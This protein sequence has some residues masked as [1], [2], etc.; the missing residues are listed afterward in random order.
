MA[1]LV[2]TFLVSFA[3]VLGAYWLF[4]LRHEIRHKASVTRRLKTY[5]AQ[6]SGAGVVLTPER[7]SSIPWLDAM[8]AGRKGLVE[9]VR[10]LVLEAG[11]TI[12]VG[13][14]LLASFCG[15]AA[16]FFVGAQLLETL[17]AALLFGILGA[18]V[19]YAYVRFKR[20]VRLR[21]FEEQFP[22]AMDL[23]SRALRAGHAF[24]TGIGMVA[25]E[26]PAPVGSEFRRLY[27]QQNFGMSLP[28]AMRE[29]ASRVPVL[30]AK[31]FVTAV[32]TQREA[33][34]NLSE[35]LDNLASVM[36]D[37]FKLRRQIRVVSAH[38]RISAF[39][40][41]ALPPVLA[42]LMFMIS[43]HL[44][45]VLTTDPVGVRLV[46]IALVLQVVGTVMIAR[47]VKIEY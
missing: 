13:T 4:V 10:V 36:R 45:S 22:E 35:V 24:T 9:R 25:D 30:D 17:L 32:L 46:L 19:P 26:I 3:T 27:D 14:F 44:M 20:S 29:M 38:G 21:A 5:R 2:T 41:C 12:N 7:L 1:L 15:G 23:I 40:L 8:L 43:P 37:R 33:G 18:A 31:F 11:L 16:G 28:E 47:M 42:V 6:T 39:V 34:G